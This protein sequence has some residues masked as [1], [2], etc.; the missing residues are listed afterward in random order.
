MMVISPYSF[1]ISLYKDMGL[2][3]IIRDIH[4]E[5]FSISLGPD[6][7]DVEDRIPFLMQ[8]DVLVGFIGIDL[9][10]I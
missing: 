8:N 3:N 2:F 4:L 7:R 10:S 6:R 5:S 9:S 1:C